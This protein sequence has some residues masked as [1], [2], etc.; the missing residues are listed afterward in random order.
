MSG[1]GVA[2]QLPAFIFYIGAGAVLCAIIA[3]LEAYG[4]RYSAKRRNAARR[5]ALRAQAWN[6]VGRIRS[7]YDWQCDG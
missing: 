1:G 5:R 6:E 2:A 3:G 7:V 4:A